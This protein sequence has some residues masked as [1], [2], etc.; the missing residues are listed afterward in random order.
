VGLG[1]EASVTGQHGTV[2]HGASG[3]PGSSRIYPDTARI[4]R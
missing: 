3:T 2:A 1:I 4:E